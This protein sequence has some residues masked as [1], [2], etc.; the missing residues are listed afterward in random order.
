[1]SVKIIAAIKDSE[2]GFVHLK[3]DP[4]EVFG[5]CLAVEILLTEKPPDSIEKIEKIWD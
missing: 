1:M 4:Q 3:L 5:L 2:N